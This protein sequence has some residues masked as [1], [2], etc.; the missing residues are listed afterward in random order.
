MKKD[1]Y[2]PLHYV[3]GSGNFKTAAALLRH[4][5][6]V[7]P[8]DASKRT[9][10]H[11]VAYRWRDNVSLLLAYGADTIAIDECGRT[12]LQIVRIAGNQSIIS[13]LIQANKVHS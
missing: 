3:A 1:V 6:K 10:L 8:L 9:P 2:T 12:A 11:H 13:R 7:N 4:D 5:A